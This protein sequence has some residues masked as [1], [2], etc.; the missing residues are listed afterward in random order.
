MANRRSYLNA[1]NTLGALLARGILP[2]VNEN[3]TVATEEIRFGDNDNLSALVA[4]LIEANLLIL[5]TDQP[6]LFTDD[7]R[8]NPAASLVAEVAEAT[9]PAD[10]WAAAGG[11]LPGLG[12]GGMATKLQAADLAR[13]SGARV[14]VARGSDPEILARVVSGERIGT[15]FHPVTSALDSRRRYILAGGAAGS[16][17]VDDGARRALQTG[18]S[19][20]AVGILS[21]EGEFDRGDTV[22]VTDVAGREVAR[23][24]VNY[25]AE[26]LGRIRG[27][28][29]N[30]IETLLGYDYGDE[31]VHHNDL[32][33]L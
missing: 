5:L 9:I 6:G 13:R 17:M 22:R 25:R 31:V 11:A 16:V 24:I 32:V 4:N 19:L 29:S 23:G 2:V 3:D 12:T 15:Q 26:D 1:R 27:R 10:L 28:H 33:L 18:A 20:L 21:T 7:P 14:V 8:K 30:E